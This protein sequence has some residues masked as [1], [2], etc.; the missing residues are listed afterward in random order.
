M[1]SLD[2]NW[3]VVLKKLREYYFSFEWYEVYDFI[4]FV[5]NNYMLIELTHIA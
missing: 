5:A 4:E 2:D 1:D 3:N